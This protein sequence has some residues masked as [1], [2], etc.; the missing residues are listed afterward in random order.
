MD[1]ISLPWHI[2]AHFVLAVL[3]GWLIGQYFKKS[4]LGVFIGFLGGFLIDLDH[5]L[6]YFLFFGP[7]FNLSNFFEGWQ[8]LLSDK[9]YLW[10]HAWEYIPILLVAAWL[11]KKYK[12]LKVILIALALTSGIHLLTDILINQYP[13][14]QYSLIYRSQR[15]F[16]AER[17]LGPERYQ[18]QLRVKRE[19]GL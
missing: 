4:Y 3:S 8:F 2:L 1:I 18:E 13:L 12:G 14:Q 11:L 16:A 10:F 19:L 6:E 7:H 9:I 17:I 5:V 15:D